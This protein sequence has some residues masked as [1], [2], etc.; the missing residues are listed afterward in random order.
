MIK[1]LKNVLSKNTSIKTTWRK[2][3]LDQGKIVA[4]A[5]TNEQTRSSE[6]TAKKARQ[7]SWL[8]RSIF[9]AS[10][11][12]VEFFQEIGDRDFNGIKVKYVWL[13][14]YEALSE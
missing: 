14:K 7:S 3:Y 10:E 4:Q 11:N 2:A 9:D 8:A 6:V 1:A 12:H 13:T 5:Q